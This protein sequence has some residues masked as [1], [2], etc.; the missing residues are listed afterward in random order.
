MSYWILEFIRV[1]IGYIFLMYLWPSVVFRKHLSGKSLTYRFAFCSTV[2]VLLI[3]TLVLSLGLFHILDGRIVFFLFYGIFIASILKEKRLRLRV[4]GQLRKLFAGKLGWKSFLT[5][6]ADD[7]KYLLVTFF[8]RLNQ[9]IKGRRLEYGILSVLILFAIAYFSYG[10][11]QNHSYGWGDMYVHHAWIYGLKEGNIFS[12]GV[13]PEAMHCFIYSMDVLFGI[14]IYSCLLFLGEIHVAALLVAVYCLFREILKS[15][16]TVYLILAAFLTIDVVCIDEIY[17]MARLQYTI[18]QEFGLYTL[19]LCTLYLVRF[20]KRENKGFDGNLFLFMTSLAASLAIHFYVT[21]MAFFLC[22]SFAVF[23]LNQ[24]FR[25][26]NFGVLVT[27]VILGVVISTLPMVLAFASGIPLQGSL[28]WGMNIINGTDTK[29]GRSQAVQTSTGESTEAMTGITAEKGSENA[30]SLPSQSQLDSQQGTVIEMESSTNVPKTPLVKKVA[31]AVIRSLKLVYQYGYVQLYGRS[32]AGWLLRFSIIAAI[33]TLVNVVISIVRLKKISFSMYAGITTASFLFMLLYAAPF[34]GLPEI[35]AGARLCLPEQIL[36]LAM[37]AI[38]ADE[39]FFLLEKTKAGHFAPQISLAGVLAIYAGTNYFG[40]FHGYLYYELTRY[41][42]A[43]ELTSEIMDAYPQYSYTIIST[44]EELYQSVEDARHEEIL[45]FYNKSRL[46]DYYIPT[47]YLFFYIEK[48]PIYY[49]QYHFFSGPRWLGQDKYTKYYEYS[50]AVLSIGDGIEH[51]EISEEA[52]GESLL[53]T[54]K[55]SDAY[56]LIINRTILESEMYHWCQEFKTRLPNEIKVYYEDEN[57]ICYVVKQNPAHL[58][59][60][61][62]E[63]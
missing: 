17:G 57:F 9:K 16:Y 56:S 53:T 47:E 61:N 31:D 28:N 3:N 38:P 39:L 26:K 22:A 35:I 45:D 50:T 8:R 60:L 34:L 58:Y 41:N 49:A 19:F 23:G 43:V 54:S 59:N 21:I 6:L 62:L 11:F 1:G 63:K 12:A 30:S 2:S 18:S 5:A 27:A 10:A 33:L 36:L 44:T 46:V 25:K 14:S 7:S 20:L 13:Y 32:R 51:S 55:A 4:S 40:V 37:M 48:N 29:E 52:V 15:R 42:A 24:I